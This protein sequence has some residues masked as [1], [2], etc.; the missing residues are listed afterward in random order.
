MSKGN[1]AQFHSGSS[2]AEKADTAV[3]SIS[4]KVQ[5]AVGDMGEKATSAASSVIHSA[6]DAATFVGNKADDGLHAVGAG[7]KSFGDTVRHSAPR[8]GMAKDSMGAVADTLENTGKFLEEE[9]FSGIAAEL[10]SM[11]KRNPVPSL[12]VGIGIGFLIGRSL[13]SRNY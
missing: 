7:L 1:T 5:D 3:S 11:I 6:Q 4:D 12:F 9:G 10:T 8:S 13:S 2:P